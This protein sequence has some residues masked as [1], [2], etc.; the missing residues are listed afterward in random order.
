MRAIYLSDITREH[1]PVIEE[2]TK[3]THPRTL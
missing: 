2:S 3:K 1:K